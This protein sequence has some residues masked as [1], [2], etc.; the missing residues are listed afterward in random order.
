MTFRKFDA[1]AHVTGRDKADCQVRALV[2]ATGMKYREAWELLYAVQGERKTC[3]FCLPDAL[4][5]G[6]SRFGVLRTLTFNAVSGKRRMTGE[7]F[8][9]DFPIGNF[10]LRLAHHVVAVEDGVLFDTWD[11]TAKCV[12]Q[13]YEVSRKVKP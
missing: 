7:K 11:S 2:T 1:G 4:R 9:H 6:D 8:C 10:I 3:G 12:Y 13:A 5:S